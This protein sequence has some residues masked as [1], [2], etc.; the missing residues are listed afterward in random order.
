[1]LVVERL[2]VLLKRMS[3][4]TRNKMQ[5]FANHYDVWDV[6]QTQWRMENVWTTKPK[7]STLAG[8]VP[9]PDYKTVCEAKGAQKP[10]KFAPKMFLQILTL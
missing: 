9:I 10:G 3:S 8:Y 6:A 2:H 5:S 1:M 7:Q 4:G